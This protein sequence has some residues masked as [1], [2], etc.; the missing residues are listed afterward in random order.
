MSRT[1]IE[2]CSR[3][4]TLPEVWNFITGCNKVSQGCKNCYAEIMHRRLQ[5]MYPKKYN[6]DFLS[7]AHLHKD[8]INL[9][10]SWT[11]PRTV[12]VNSMSDMF[13]ENISFPVI[14]EAF[15]V[16]TAQAPQ[17]TYIIL[18]KRPERLLEYVQWKINTGIKGQ[19]KSFSKNIWLLVSTEDQKTADERIPLLLQVPCHVHGISAEPLLGTIILKP[20]WKLQWVIAGGESGHHARPMHPHWALSLRDQC[21]NNGIPFFFKQHGAWLNSYNYGERLSEL[22][23]GKTLPGYFSF[24]DGIHVNKVGKHKAGRLLDGKEW[25]QFPN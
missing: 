6:H 21:A 4:G 14:N 16:M 9:P 13:H 17:H 18:T 23:N 15:D 22:Y 7:G 5:Y 19:W 1:S 8:L 11:K 10:L 24:P 25:N 3:P 20:E 2:W 12:F